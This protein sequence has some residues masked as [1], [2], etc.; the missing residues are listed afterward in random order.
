MTDD[1]YTELVQAQISIGRILGRMT[2]IIRAL[3]DDAT[4][5]ADL[6]REYAALLAQY[7]AVR[8]IIEEAPKD[9]T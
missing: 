5:A 9:G 2:E 8:A 1:A 7:R 4:D 6:R 3:D